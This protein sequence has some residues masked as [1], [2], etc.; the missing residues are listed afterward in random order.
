MGKE[1]E[2]EKLF[3]HHLN[4]SRIMRL[5]L[6]GLL[7]SVFASGTNAFTTPSTGKFGV[8]GLSRVNVSPYMDE[9]IPEV[10]NENEKM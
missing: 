10:G 1:G 6:V 7:A 4:I 3:H 8:S 5:F 2:V 9:P